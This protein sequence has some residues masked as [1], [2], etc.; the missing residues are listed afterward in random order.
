MVDFGVEE[1][2]NTSADMW[3]AIAKAQN[4]YTEELLRQGYSPIQAATASYVAARALVLKFSP[5]VEPFINPEAKE[6]VN[7]VIKAMDTLARKKAQHLT[8]LQVLA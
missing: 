1:L 5:I 7:V 4:A 6:I 2:S 8:S 3:N